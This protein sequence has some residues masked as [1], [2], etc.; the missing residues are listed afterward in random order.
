MGGQACGYR[1]AQAV[2][3]AE[4]QAEIY[5]AT[6][7]GYVAFCE[8]AYEQ[9]EI[10]AWRAGGGGRACYGTGG[11]RS[12]S[13]VGSRSGYMMRCDR[14]VIGRHRGGGV[15][16]SISAWIGLSVK[17]SAPTV[18]SV[19]A[20]IESERRGSRNMHQTSPSSP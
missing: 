20:T 13:M 19:A 6:V 18:L 4:R 12:I 8:R 1:K 5:L 3:T 11:I 15:G 17:P 9:V 2:V 14:V 7:E 16:A 10:R